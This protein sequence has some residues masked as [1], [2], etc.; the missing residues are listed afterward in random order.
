MAEIIN[1]EE[2]SD[3][4]LA[5][6]SIEDQSGFLH[7]MNR[8]QTKLLYYIRRISGV[9]IEEAEDVLQDVFIKVYRNLNDFDHDLK[10]SS[11]VYRIAHNQVISDYRKKQAR[12]QSAGIDLSDLSLLNLASGLDIKKDIDNQLL[13]EAINQILD[14]MPVKYREVLILKFF[15]EKDYAEISDIL[16]KPMGTVA[17]LLN[18]AKQKF[19]EEYEK[20]KS[21]NIQ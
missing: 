6:L 18:R 2:K 21:A 11:W 3:E 17:S 4:E 5:F 1:Y 12:P 7:I 14:I 9:S 13:R 16:K 15:E 20:R 8:Y 10:F 19:R